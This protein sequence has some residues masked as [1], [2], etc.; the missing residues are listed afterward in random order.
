MRNLFK[1]DIDT[2]RI[3][4]LDIL[5]ALAI[6]FVLIAHSSNLLSKDLTK[7]NNH[8]VFDGVSIF[9][10]LS[11]F[12]IGGILIRLID[13][14]GFSF[15]TLIN[16]WIRRWFR[17]LPN[18]FL[19]LIVLCV[20]H[21]AFDPAFT[22]SM[23]FKYFIF[24]QNLWTKHPWF[25]PE[26]WSLSVEEWFYIIFPLLI[27]I[28]LFFQKSYKKS[29]LFIAVF[30]IILATAFR[31]YRFST[32]S[33]NGVGDWDILFRKQVITRLDSLMFGVLGA[34]IS[35]FHHRAWTTF[36]IQFLY[37]GI[38]L[39][40]AWKFILPKFT[41]YDDLY[42]CVFR[43]TIFSIATLF[44]LPYLSQLKTG[45]GFLYKI[46]TYLSLI[47]YSA[48]L[49]NF[50]LV[51]RWIIGSI[52]WERITNDTYVIGASNYFLF[53]FLV[54]AMSILI[55]KHFEVPMTSLREK[56]K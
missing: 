10:V 34:Y 36:K 25:Y 29:L 1:I 56:F 7:I 14:N 30:I 40:L 37:T 9:F 31:I 15:Y 11:G 45:K 35:F 13:K 12:L 55:Y 4:G 2:G 49:I 18:Y 17:T 3:F 46:I 41:K 54:I 26:A 33:L 47:S 16:F 50:T 44:L 27:F 28:A 53:W 21:Y 8:F 20:L 23:A 6:I 39:F 24:S 51:Q 22:I 48:Y 42:F 19:I 43:F 5:R 32:V 52:P 38:F